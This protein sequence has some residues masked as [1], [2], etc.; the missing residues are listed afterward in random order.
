MSDLTIA[1]NDDVN[2]RN[3]FLAKRLAEQ[4]CNLGISIEQLSKAID[5]SEEEYLLYENGDEELPASVA[6]LASVI[7]G[8]DPLIYFKELEENTDPSAQVARVV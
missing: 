4:R 2:Q 7:L 6:F 3:S 1:I 8:Q 5:I